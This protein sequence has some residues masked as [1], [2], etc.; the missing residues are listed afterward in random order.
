MQSKDVNPVNYINFPLFNEKHPTVPIGENIRLIARQAWKAITT[1]NKWY[2]TAI[3][4]TLAIPAAIILLAVTLT[5]LSLAILFHCVAI[6]IA[7]SSHGWSKKEAKNHFLSAID[8]LKSLCFAILSYP[9]EG[10]QFDHAP[11]GEEA[12]STPIILAHGYGHNSSGWH[13]I[14]KKLKEAGAGP[15]Y[16]INF[17][18]P[19]NSIHDFAEKLKKKAEKVAKETGRS[20]L[21]LVG[22]SMGGI[23]SSYYATTLAPKNTVRSVITL[24]SPLRGSHMAK[25]TIGQCARDMARG[26][27]FSNALPEK[28]RN[29]KEIAFF[30]FGAKTD[31]LIRP[32]LS[33]RLPV[34]SHINGHEFDRLG[35]LS[36][37]YSPVVAHAVTTVVKTFAIV[38]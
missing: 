20:D 21:I 30:N 14:R 15:I 34:E 13:L 31:M 10:T 1:P 38:V 11:T 28:I 17:G 23:V 29:A 8:D 32:T 6:P 3:K 16:T 12:H 26:S 22:H 33:A 36:Y 27:A 9:V 2:L 5:L 35:H 24:G 37:Q 25:I 7:L 18:T 4:A 19:F